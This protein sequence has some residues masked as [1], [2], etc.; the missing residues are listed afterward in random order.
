MF[1]TGLIVGILYQIYIN[2]M[3]NIVKFFLENLVIL[4][5][6]VFIFALGKANIVFAKSNYK[7]SI[8]EINEKNSLSIKVF[9]KLSA[10]L[11]I[12]CIILFFYKYLILLAL[13]FINE[14]L[15]KNT[16]SN[17]QKLLI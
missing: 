9:F 1:F 12:F 14:N 10:K 13:I 7:K 11:I 16:K 2:A 17:Y 6:R 5:K 8:L 15:V 4:I 3:Q